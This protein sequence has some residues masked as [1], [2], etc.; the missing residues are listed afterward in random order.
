M[1]LVYKVFI[2]FQEDQYVMR[3]IASQ[4]TAGSKRRVSQISRPAA[5]SRQDDGRTDPLQH[6]QERSEIDTEG[7]AL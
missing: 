5:T 3:N 6:V 1:S 7:S 4:L 2:G